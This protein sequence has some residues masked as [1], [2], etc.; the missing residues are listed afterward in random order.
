M[1]NFDNT[2]RGAL[3]VNDRKTAP[4]QPDYRGNLADADG[5]EYWVSAWVKT[6][7]KGE[8]LSMAL[9]PK[10][11]DQPARGRATASDASDFLA[12]NRAKIDAH[13]PQSPASPQPDYDS[14][15]DDI[16]F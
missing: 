7:R 2:L 16:P 6:G 3:F 5:R 12:R 11:E 13:R 4:N 15:D 9:T 10:D 8:Y 1:S 14:F